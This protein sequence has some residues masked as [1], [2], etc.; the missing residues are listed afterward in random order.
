MFAVKAFVLVA[1]AACVFAADDKV[2]TAA[3]LPCAA[4]VTVNVSSS[5]N[6][7]SSKVI[8]MNHF[9]YRVDSIDNHGYL[10]VSIV[11]VGEVDDAPVILRHDY[12]TGNK[13]LCQTSTLTD[14]TYYNFI[15]GALGSIVAKDVEFDSVSKGSVDG[16]ECTI[17]TRQATSSGMPATQVFYADTDGYLIR[18]DLNMT[19]GAIYTVY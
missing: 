13:R 11:K 3:D 9:S 14:T 17:Y 18:T 1:L 12:G 4:Q 10:T 19:L 15:S 2:F 8:Y 6:G 7:D 5:V 16:K